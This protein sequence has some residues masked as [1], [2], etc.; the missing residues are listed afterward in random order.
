MRSVTQ[1]QRVS[2]SVSDILTQVTATSSPG[3]LPS[4]PRPGSALRP[5]PRADG[6]VAGGLGPAGS[7]GSARA[8]SRGRGFPIPLPR[9]L[10]R[11]ADHRVDRAQSAPSLAAELTSRRWAGP[12]GR[13]G[14]SGE[15]PARERA[16]RPCSAPQRSRPEAG[17]SA[18]RR[19]SPCLTHGARE[20]ARERK[21]QTWRLRS[22]PAEEGEAGGG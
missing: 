10:A 6:G 4:T 19:R 16:A 21:G 22:A 7:E 5:G 9:E 17:S 15:Q 13:G 14:A 11:P 1:V 2:P 3:T 8:P 12:A 20:R 18:L